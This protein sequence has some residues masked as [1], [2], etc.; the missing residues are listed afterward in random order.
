LFHDGFAKMAG[1]KQFTRANVLEGAMEVF[2]KC[3]YEATSISQLVAATG[4]NRASI[5]ATFGDKKGLFL[6]VLD[7]YADTVAKPLMTELADPDPRRA[8]ERMFESII[9][10]TSDPRFPRGCLN[11]N[12]SLECPGR[13]DEITRKIAEGFG[14]QES[15]IYRVLRRA[16]ANGSLSTALDARALARFFMAVAQGLNVVNKAVAD[17]T[18]LQ[19]IARAAMTVWERGPAKR[20]QI[21][22]AK[23]RAKSHAAF[24]ASPPAARK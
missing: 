20:G 8:I 12:T 16:Q 6:A 21:S 18:I 17:P 7:H 13:G 19:D 1:V 15:A 9:V 4:I 22:Y 5:Y 3:G 14:R 2:W 11:T 10:R 24:K 23:M